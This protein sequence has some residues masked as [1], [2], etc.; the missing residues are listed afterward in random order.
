VAANISEVW[1][2]EIL[3]ETYC[4]WLIKINIKCLVSLPTA[5]SIII[6]IAFKQLKQKNLLLIYRTGTGGDGSTHYPVYNLLI[7][8][9]IFKPVV[10]RSAS[11]T[12][13]LPQLLQTGYIAMSFLCS[14]VT[15]IN[16]CIWMRSGKGSPQKGWSEILQDFFSP[17]TLLRHIDLML[18]LF[19]QETPW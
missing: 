4:G 8:R 14:Q 16:T 3:S 6:F 12:V 13:Y 19:S 1:L 10:W 17:L 5:T 18:H 9:L 7:L 2:A 11:Q 15:L